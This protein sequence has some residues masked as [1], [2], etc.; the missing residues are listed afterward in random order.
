LVSQSDCSVDIKAA[1]GFPMPEISR[2]LGL[3]IAMYYAD[4]RPPHFHVRYGD[5][6]AIIGIENGEMLAGHL[7]RRALAL[8]GEWRALHVA[9]LMEDWQLAEMHR[10]LKNIDPLE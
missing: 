10:P 6:E 9:E 8:V 7:P 1:G 4:H 5:H 2:F 3:V